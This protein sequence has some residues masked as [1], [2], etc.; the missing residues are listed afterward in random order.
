MLCG[1]AGEVVVEACGDARSVLTCL[2]EAFWSYPE[3]CHLL[4]SER[5]RRRV[6]PRYLLADAASSAR[7]GSLVRASLGGRVVGAAA[8]VPPGGYPIRLAD[9]AREACHVL[10][11]APWGL[12]ALGEARRGRAANQAAHAGRP[13]HRW[14]RAVGVS[15]EVQGQG[16]GSA[17]LE[18]GI[19]AA[20]RDGVGC[21]LVTATEAN[22]AWYQRFG[23]EP[24]AD[25]RPTP[26]WPHTWALWRPPT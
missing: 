2:T 9:Q 4:P 1:M 24:V 8:W 13:P 7:S 3:T 22:V 15:P 10:P 23:F 11:A 25:Y 26:R 19:G 20:D 12:A 16:V 21:F 5:A 14:L 17:L 6:L 18:H